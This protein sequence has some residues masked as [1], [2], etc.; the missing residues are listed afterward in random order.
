MN[1][2]FLDDYTCLRTLSFR[3]KVTY[4]YISFSLQI[5][6]VAEESSTKSAHNSNNS[7]NTHIPIT[8]PQ[9]PNHSSMENTSH[10][11][12]RETVRVFFSHDAPEPIAIYDIGIN[13]A[14]IL[15]DL[16][17]SGA[18]V[19]AI[20]LLRRPGK[21]RVLQGNVERGDYTAYTSAAPARTRKVKEVPRNDDSDEQSGIYIARVTKMSTIQHDL[22]SLKQHTTSTGAIVTVTMLCLSREIV[23]FFCPFKW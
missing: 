19:G 1:T 7:S 21:E 16:R 3:D 20:G 22:L 4:I 2:H 6:S 12:T 18:V 14:L 13:A 11:L 8:Q 9:T 10:S 15:R 17:D 5:T 23:H